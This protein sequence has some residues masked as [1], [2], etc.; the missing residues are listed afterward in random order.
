MVLYTLLGYAPGRSYPVE[1]SGAAGPTSACCGP[2]ASIAGPGPWWA[3]AGFACACRTGGGRARGALCRRGSGPGGLEYFENA[4]QPACEADASGASG[5]VRCNKIGQ[6]GQ[7][8]R[9]QGKT[10]CSGFRPPRSHCTNT[11]FDESSGSK[12]YEYEDYTVDSSIVTSTTDEFD[13]GVVIPAGVGGAC[14]W[15]YEYVYMYGH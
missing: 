12:D 10:A 14:V 7:C 5:S 11:Q 1:A 6:A 3:N 2:P 8:E 4:A 15:V 13:R 9:T